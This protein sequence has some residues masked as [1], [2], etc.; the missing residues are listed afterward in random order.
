MCLCGRVECAALCWVGVTVP[1]SHLIVLDIQ[2]ITS[3]NTLCLF[4]LSGGSSQC[5]PHSAPRSLVHALLPQQ[6]KA[7]RRYVLPSGSAQY[8]ETRLARLAIHSLAAVEA[9]A[10]SSTS[11]CTAA[12]VVAAPAGGTYPLIGS[13]VP[14][15]L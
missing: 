7:P 12:A 5:P 10:S 13:P 15:V 6:R 4:S 11:A 3:V 14:H 8:L 9:C 1:C 2:Y